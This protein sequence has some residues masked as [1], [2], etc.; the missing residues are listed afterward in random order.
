MKQYKELMVYV[1]TKLLL[2]I[3]DICLNLAD[4]ILTEVEENEQ[5]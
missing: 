1:V 5:F 4:K 2:K 3:S